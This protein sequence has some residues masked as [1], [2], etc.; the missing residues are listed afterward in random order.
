[1]YKLVLILLWAFSFFLFLISNRNIN[2][3]SL[4]MEVFQNSYIRDINLGDRWLQMPASAYFPDQFFYATART[5]FSINNSLLIVAILKFILLF[6]SLRY[7]IKAIYNSNNS[8][9]TLLSLIVSLMFIPS[10]EKGIMPLYAIEYNHFSHVI[11][12]LIL[13]P[14]LI[15][16]RPKFRFL[17]LITIFFISFLTG[18]STSISLIITTSYVIGYLLLEYLESNSLIDFK[19]LF[20]GKKNYLITIFSGIILGH[21]AYSKFINQNFM[22]DRLLQNSIGNKLFTGVMMILEYNPEVTLFSIILI[23]IGIF[24]HL[25]F[26]SIYIVDKINKI[27]TISFTLAFVSIASLGG[28]VDNGYYRYFYTFIIIHLINLSYIIS[29]NTSAI[30]FNACIS[31]LFLLPYK[32]Y[33]LF[34]EINE[35]NRLNILNSD[36][37]ECINR[38]IKL[39]KTDLR[40]GVGIQDYWDANIGAVQLKDSR[41]DLV[42]MNLDGSP[43]LWMQN[44]GTMSSKY[45]DFYLVKKNNQEYIF[46]HNT[47][48]LANCENSALKIYKLD[49]NKHDFVE[50]Y[51]KISDFKLKKLNNHRNL[52]HWPGH[53]FTSTTGVTNKYW[54]LITTRG[55]GILYI[56]KFDLNPGKFRLRLLYSLMPTKIDSKVYIETVCVK[57]K[58]ILMTY[59][60]SSLKNGLA[61]TEELTFN[62]SNNKKC[63][64]KYQ[65]I[66]TVDGDQILYVNDLMI[67]RL[68]HSI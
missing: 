15:A 10:Y 68:G 61:N 21:F 44:I 6:I 30:F 46:P 29:C 62:I 40:V 41:I 39:E 1:M 32:N 23:L 66:I 53:K 52:K 18:L 7:F 45:N 55:K 13:L 48:L 28:V 11:L 63:E 9:T 43:R 17:F 58:Q 54:K 56:P 24:I 34:N 16:S 4:Y 31:S 49:D 27:N 38:S 50:Y 33:F 19:L 25:K 37:A 8:R 42:V 22:G 26:K 51:K 59:A 60:K 64:G 36:I 5:F 65:V 12:I 2:S 67:N 35:N 20:L 3:D 14:R 47:S 57:N